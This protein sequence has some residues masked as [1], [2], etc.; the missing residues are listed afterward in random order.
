M[1]RAAAVFENDLNLK[2]TELRLG[3]PGRDHESE[4]H[5][6]SSYVKINNKRSCSEMDNGSC[7]KGEQQESGAPAPK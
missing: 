4:E 1:E 7:Q 3:L 5:S 2:A 6:S